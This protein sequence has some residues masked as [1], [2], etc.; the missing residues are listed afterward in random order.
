MSHLSGKVAIVTG[1]SKGIGAAIAERLAA[2]G[3][4]VVVNY[5]RSAEDADKV[6]QRIVSTGGEAFACRADISNPSD[7]AP[8]IEA[9]VGAFGRLDI[10]INNAGVYKQDSLEAL[11]AESFDEHFNLNVRG[12]LLTTQ[13][14]ARVMKAGS[15]IV[16]ISSGLAHSPYP[17]VHV[18]CAT[19]G[20]VNT[21]T[22]SLAMEL[23]PR[24]IRV[25]GIAPG[26]VH[27]EGNAES[28]KGMDEFF[29][30]KTPMGRVGK[31]KDIAASVAYVVSED[32]AWVTG[33]TIDVAG[34]M[35]F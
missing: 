12:L 15:V 1:S 5:S 8:L 32:A 33:N 2:D 4:K 34:G 9:A 19:K 7:I 16:N 30:A 18:Y 29:T 24:G 27:T 28:A 22:R 21:L 3:A 13:A 6:V 25:V 20:A 11:S 26:F 10:L 31:P 14:A 23:G 35:I 17:S